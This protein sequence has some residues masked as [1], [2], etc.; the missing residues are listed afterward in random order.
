M[1]LLAA[2]PG[3]EV[4]QAWLDVQAER[5]RQV[6]AEGW[7]PEHD[8]EH[9]CDEIAAFACF[10]A[11]PP[12]ARDRDTSSTGYGDTLG[13]AI[14][15]EGWEPKTGDRRRELVK[16]GGLILAEIER[17]DRTAATQGGPRDA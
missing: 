1:A 16:A 12:A 10:Y 3:K 17:L 4:P 8:D 7:T 5:R 15:P 2:A 11:M 6:E 14:L 13:E 9:A